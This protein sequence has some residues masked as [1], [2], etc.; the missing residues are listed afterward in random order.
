MFNL[1][2]ILQKSCFF[3]PIEEFFEKIQN[4]H[5]EKGH[6]GK[7]IMQKYLATK[8]ANVTTE[9]INI[10]RS[11]CEKCWLKKS[12]AR[13]G[14]VVKPILTQNVMSRGQVDMIDMQSQPDGV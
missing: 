10:Y 3:V 13:R 14:V 2:I 9:H 4:A 5:I 6:P 12:K 8:Y 1:E 7:D 11:F